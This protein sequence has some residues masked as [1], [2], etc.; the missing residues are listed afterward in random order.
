[1]PIPEIKILMPVSLDP[2]VLCPNCKGYGD[3]L[4]YRKDAKNKV[5]LYRIECSWCRGNG[6]IGRYRSER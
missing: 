1:M 6:M 5:F 2:P 4:E 3:N